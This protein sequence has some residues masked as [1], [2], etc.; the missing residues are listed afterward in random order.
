MSAINGYFAVASAT[1]IAISAF[2]IKKGCKDFQRGK[3][4]QGF[5]EIGF[6]ALAAGAALAN[7]VF[8]FTLNT[9]PSR[10]SSQDYLRLQDNENQRAF[11]LKSHGMCTPG[12][13]SI[14]TIVNGVIKTCLPSGQ[15]AD[16]RDSIDRT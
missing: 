2:S 3:K 7:G 15:F 16:A 12:A 5:I 6:G 1:C 14:S 10:V 9:S 4:I 11:N 13:Y 8:A